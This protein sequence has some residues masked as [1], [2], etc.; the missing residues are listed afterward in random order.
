MAVRH[1][2]MPFCRLVLLF[3]LC[4]PA[5]V[6]FIPSMPQT[7]L[8]ASWIQAL[9]HMDG[10]KFG[11]D[12][13]FTFG[14]IGYA[15]MPA[16]SAH[17][18]S[19]PEQ[20]GLAALWVVVAWRWQEGTR[21]PWLMLVGLFLSA[22][23][24]HGI[25]VRDTFF[26]LACCLAG[27]LALREPR[28]DRVLG[29]LLL[30]WLGLM[31][32]SFLVMGVGLAALLLIYDLWAKR[33]PTTFL[34]FVLC[35]VAG[36]LLTGQSLGHVYQ[37]WRGLSEIS[38][39]YNTDMAIN[40]AIGHLLV[41]LLFASWF[42]AR[43][44]HACWQNRQASIAVESLILCF[45]LFISF[46]AAFVR[47]DVHELIAF[48]VLTG[49]VLFRASIRPKYRLQLVMTMCLAL[50]AIRGQVD[51][52]AA[53]RYAA[54]EAVATYCQQF[55]SMLAWLHSPLALQGDLAAAFKEGSAKIRQQL[56]DFQ[57]G[58]TLDVYPTE[59]S[60][61]F[62]IGAHWQ[63]R[64][65]FQS[66]SAYTP[67]LAEL[68]RVHLR[69]RGAD[70]LLFGLSSIDGRYPS[71]DDGPSWP[72][73]LALYQPAEMVADR[74]LALRR[75]ADRPHE[76]LRPLAGMQMALGEWVAL[77]QSR[78][79]P[80]FI[81]LHL[82]PTTWG[83]LANL[84]YKRPPVYLQ[85]EL[86]D[87]RK[88]RHR[89][90]EGSAAA[91]FIVSPYLESVFDIGNLWLEKWPGR[92]Q[93]AQV[94]RMKVEV[95]AHAGPAFFEPMIG[96]EQFEIHG[97]R[98]Q[99]SLPASLEAPAWMARELH[100]VT[101]APASPVASKQGGY[102]DSVQQSGALLEV[103]GWIPMPDADKVQRLFVAVPSRP[104]SYQVRAIERR[105]VGNYLNNKNVI[106]AGFA[107]TLQFASAADAQSASKDL[108]I[109]Y[110]S[111]N[112]DLALVKSDRKSCNRF[113]K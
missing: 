60:L 107:F 46:K 40:G 30:A 42:I 18:A 79:V 56:G 15:Y 112:T 8:D 82:V 5:L 95:D 87:G 85:V 54:S 81:R 76:Q 26:M 21:S 23:L 105:D 20:V 44:V 66:Y 84:A 74:W 53:A 48:G 61:V 75:A 101:Q 9:T 16:M 78:N 37:Y 96:L 72:T 86:A 63:P 91:G 12:I 113:L 103:N 25:F 106:H 111:Q 100:I 65:V 90:P 70:E 34:T 28:L 64:P 59:Q 45:V 3:L 27:M 43:E 80:V 19:I 51:S 17:G 58:G 93:S 39:G 71:I 2:F 49:L 108:C 68:N 97:Y 104:Q 109:A 50:M 35:W 36:W 22:W 14:P 55:K 11:L 110:Q 47:Q 52:A 57:S 4:L 102:I 24:G 41:Y 77:P 33:F 13:V 73:M 32:G 67:Y 6:A 94:L 89:I 98:R 99:Q 10:K 7:G 1:H 69:E 92:L 29:G 31:K 88:I 83:R 62:A 38:N